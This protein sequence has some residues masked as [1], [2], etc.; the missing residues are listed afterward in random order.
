M[1]NDH[2]PVNWIIGI[3]KI[4]FLPILAI[5]EYTRKKRALRLCGSLTNIYIFLK[6]NLNTVSHNTREQKKDIPKRLQYSIDL[7]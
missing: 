1:S 4:P 7:Y 3:L 6:V 5:L 2:Y